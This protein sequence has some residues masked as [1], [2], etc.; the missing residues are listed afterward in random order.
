M[1]R[2]GRSDD[3]LPPRPEAL[4]RVGRARVRPGRR[5]RVRLLTAQGPVRQDADRFHRP[6]TSPRPSSAVSVPALAARRLLV[7]DRDRF[8][9]LL[10]ARPDQD[11]AD[12]D[13]PRRTT[14][15]AGI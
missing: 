4:L 3:G 8:A 5:R 12:I 11:L 1:K 10:R 9:G 7:E 2:A 13:G 6:T 15:R 14:G